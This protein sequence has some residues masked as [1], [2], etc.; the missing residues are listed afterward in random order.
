MTGAPPGLKNKTSRR[1][2]GLAALAINCRPSGAKDTLPTRVPNTI[3]QSVVRGGLEVMWN[4]SPAEHGLAGPKGTALLRC[5]FPRYN[6]D[7][8]TGIDQLFDAL[9]Q[10]FPRRLDFSF[11]EVRAYLAGELRRA[12]GDRHRNGN[13]NGIFSRCFF[14]DE[15]D[16]AVFRT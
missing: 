11:F 5:F 13:C 3:A 15:S 7:H 12:H 10:F 16:C 2:Q 4:Q 14:A 9:F 8:P 1:F 6:V